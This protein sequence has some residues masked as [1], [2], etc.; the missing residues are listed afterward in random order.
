M[1]M[2]TSVLAIQD[3]M[4]ENIYV[5]EGDSVKSAQLTARLAE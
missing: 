5:K 3:G 2:E 1:K 4:A